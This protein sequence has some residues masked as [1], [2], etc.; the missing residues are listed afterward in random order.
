MSIC[1][2]KIHIL[3]GKF[4]INFVV[5]FKAQVHSNSL[6]RILK[7]KK[8]NYLQLSFLFLQEAHFSLLRLNFN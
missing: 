5:L 6:F 8:E 7:L 4:S 1:E 2:Q 3:Y